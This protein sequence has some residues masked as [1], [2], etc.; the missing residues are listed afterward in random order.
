MVDT[1]LKKVL[2]R[3]GSQPEVSRAT[4]QWPEPPLRG[5]EV[6]VETHRG[7]ELATVLQYLPEKIEPTPYGVTEDPDSTAFEVVRPATYEDRRLADDLRLDCE[8][9]FDVWLDRIRKWNL[10][11]QLID[12]EWPLDKSKLILYVLNDRGGECTKMAIYAAAEG[13]GPVEVQPVDRTGLLVPTSEGG[14]GGCGSCGSGGGG[15][16]TDHEP[17]TTK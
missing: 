12:L 15:C 2:V 5:A 13:F 4:V 9:Q 10:D 7:L 1:T 6:V 8:S 14:G 16:S 3:Y 11:L 17:A